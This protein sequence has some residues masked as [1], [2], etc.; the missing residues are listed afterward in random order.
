V[1]GK[2]QLAACGEYPQPIVRPLVGGCTEEC[3]FAQIGPS[4][5][6]GHL[7]HGQLVGVVDDSH[8]VP[9]R[10]PIGEGVDLG[11]P[12]HYDSLP[13]RLGLNWLA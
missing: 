3:R 6:I 2:R 9:E 4:R 8:W 10:Q 11:E 12:M 1:A 13:A 7:L 5:E